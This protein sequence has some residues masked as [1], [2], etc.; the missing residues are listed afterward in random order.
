M[1]S[2]CKSAHTIS[3]ICVK[4]ILFYSCRISKLWVNLSC[5]FYTLIHFLDFQFFFLFLLFRICK[6]HWLLKL[7]LQKGSTPIP[8][9]MFIY[10]EIIKYIFLFIRIVHSCRVKYKICLAFHFTWFPQSIIF[11]HSFPLFLPNILALSLSYVLELNK[12]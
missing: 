2:F 4:D 7:K 8:C 10:F 11:S 5:N 1:C 9:F 6:I 12:I 3:C